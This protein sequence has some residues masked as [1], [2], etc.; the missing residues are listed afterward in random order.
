MDNATIWNIIN[1]YFQDNPKALVRHHIDS[2]NDFYKN[3][4]FKIFREKNP[5]VLYS[6]LDPDTNEYL[7]QCKMYMG[8]KDG[9]KIYFGKPVIHDEG[10]VHYMYP[11]EARLRNMNYSMTIHYDIDVEFIDQLQPGET[12][13]IIG[14]ELVKQAKDGQITMD[15][16]PDEEENNK[17]SLLK[18]I[19]GDIEKQIEEVK[20]GEI[21]ES[22]LK[23]QLGGAGT[24]K[25]TKIKRKKKDELKL[26]MTTK[27]AA[28]LRDVSETSLKGNTQTRIH[29]LEKIFLGK[30][31]I[32]LQS[33]FC[34][35]NNLPKH[36]RHTMGECKNDLGGYFIVDGKE[37]TVVAQEKFADN[38]LYIKKV[39]DEKYLY[40]AEMRCVSEN[41]SKPVRTF[42]VKIC[43][44]TNKYTNKQIVVKIPNVRSPVPLFIVFR[45]LGIISDKDIISYCLLDLDKYESLIDLFIPSVHDAST[46]MTQQNALKYIALLTKGK[47]ISHALEI[48]TDFFLPHVGE[49]NYIAK[50]YALGDIVYRLI[51]VYTGSELP[52]DRDNFKY[53]RIELVGSLLY[54]L[55][56]EYWTIQLRSVHLEFEKRLYYNQELY[57]NNLFGLITQNYKDVFRERDLEK[58]FKKA[59]KGN[60]G[61]HTHTKRIGAVQDLNRLSFN[62]AL[63]H[64]R[65][66]NL[67]LDS[68]V[69]LVG[70]RVLHNSQWGYVDP[71]DTPDGGS[72]GLHKHLSLS[73]YITRGVSREPMIEWLR[74]KWGMKLIEEH[75]PSSLSRIT[76]VV[77]NGFMVGAVDEPLECIKTFRLYRR[78]ALIPIYAS[79]TFDIRLKTIFV[80][81]DSGRLCRPIFY[82]DEQTGQMSYQSKNILKKLQENDFSW[83]ELI[84]GFNKKREAVLFEPSQMRI[85]N[86]YDLYEGVEQET[87]PAKLDRFLK[88]KAVLDYIDN[89]ESEHTMIAI[90]TDEYEKDGSKLNK[91]THCEIHNSLIF[92]MMSNMIIFPENNPAT[93]N[94]FSCGQSKQA[95]SMY[96]TNF[97]VRMDKTA[98]LLNYGQT[99]LV[100]SRYLTHITQEENPYGENIIVAIACYTGYNVEDAVLVNEGSIKRGLFRTS[101]ISC[102]EAHEETDTTA[103]I[104]N[105]KKFMNIYDNTQITGTKFGTDY[106]K[107][108]KHGIIKEG[109]I[110]ND[111]TA[112]IGLANITSPVPGT[113]LNT[114]STF[115]DSSKFPKKGQLGIVDKAFITDDEDGKRIA[116][117]RVL[118][119]RIP[120]I[121]DKLASRAGQKG[122]VGL[123]VPER[124]MPFTREGLRPDVIINPH[125]IPSRMT[126]GQLVE[127]ITGK[128]CAMMGGF[129]DCT[130]FNNKG[131]KIGVY[132]ELLTKQGFHSNG[133]EILYNGMTGEQME[134]EIFMGPTYY[135]RLKHMVKDKVNSRRK[136]P[137]TALTKQP[138]SGR[139]NDGGLR[140]GEMERDTVISHGMNEF[141]KESMMER[142]DKYY[143]AICNHSGLISIYNPS[144]KLFMSPIMDGPVQ[145]NGSLENDTMRIEHVTKFGRSFSIISI[146]YS[147]K[148]LVQELQT[149]NIQLRI[150]TEDNIEQIESMS[151]SDNIKKVTQNELMQPNGLIRAIFDKLNKKQKDLKTPDQT[152]T[153]EPVIEYDK[154][155]K[156]LYIADTKQNREWFVKAVLDDNNIAISTKDL[157]NIEPFEKS[158]NFLSKSNDTLVLAVS[159]SE[160]KRA[161]IAESPDSPPFA[162]GSPAYAPGSPDYPPGS[163]AY[164][165][166]SPAYAPGSPAY[167]P[168][169][170][171]YAPGSPAYN[172]NSPYVSSE[173]GSI[174]PP[175]LEESDE[176]N[177]GQIGG[178]NKY[179]QGDRVCMRNCKDNYPKRPWEVSH[180]GPKFI[181]IKAI[182]DTGL[183]DNN[184]VNVVSGYDIFPESQLHIFKPELFKPALQNPL[185]LQPEIQPKQQQP[186]VII[187][188]KFFN[189]DGSDHSTSELPT[190]ETTTTSS[191]QTTMNNEP[192][193]VVKENIQSTPSTLPPVETAADVDFSNLVIKKVDR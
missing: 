129:G 119:Q 166:G 73:T 42:S 5:I 52:T 193:I 89:S 49:T 155:D 37:K 21:D 188:P 186:T 8:G 154:H 169:S 190:A 23:E 179:N 78:N 135:M 97:Q 117:I 38:M 46:I 116:K 69:K 140:I 121:G 114:T 111:E 136:G 67:P 76:K 144:K 110:V 39:D 20:Q 137:T 118:E 113:S 27:A 3:G 139:A 120:A 100:K 163:P 29:T 150:V 174:P 40:S 151:Y 30:F 143:L 55:F 141:L 148:L 88:N 75:T 83:S 191:E 171:A 24:P 92:G 172:P 99:P 64:L 101:Y 184:S 34:I 45:A 103:E 123:V 157:E 36:I 181:T 149:M 126:I 180:V 54:D 168:G 71:I 96:H 125:A 185:T 156:V 182:D 16:Y 192:S 72:I 173:D 133:N 94:S 51:S 128:A 12:P 170:P 162:P 187:A 66:T 58:G 4:I 175:P 105:E 138:V 68:S 159:K 22:Q 1:T 19:N 183:S 107:L 53:K 87:N 132:G 158:G 14:A 147:F 10:N 79:A 32:M 26:E 91:Y 84:T 33:E 85:Y 15:N 2:Y 176:D 81:T 77:I 142:A 13:T 161:S 112:L 61:A 18:S 7:S 93:R 63:N 35:L 106:S 108:D 167:P 80:Y 11:N 17:P 104:I 82:K 160:I 65:K 127:S 98:V 41:A 189:G 102:Y 9:S 122:T 165:P 70:P 131:S 95:C 164:P 47:G 59:F 134:S 57:E 115:V 177:D 60:W 152:F 178:G 43:T 25:K 109:T 31:P 130:A 48:L 62:S 28:K 50:A 146:P 74:E 153:P 124:D 56:R 6:N 90:N 86:L 145:F 44:P